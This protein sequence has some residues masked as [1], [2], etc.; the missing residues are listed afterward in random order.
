MYI[1]IRCIYIFLNT[2]FIYLPT[3]TYQWNC[4]QYLWYFAF[5]FW[6]FCNPFLSFNIHLFILSVSIYLSNDLFIY[7]H[8]FLSIFEQLVLSWPDRPSCNNAGVWL[9]PV[10]DRSRYMSQQQQ[11]IYAYNTDESQ[12][13]HV[14]NTCRCGT[15]LPVRCDGK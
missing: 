3:Q 6:S 15:M 8:I 9:D 2:I 12:K 5:Y 1:L 7:L 14:E 13:E 11:N 10:V 4:K